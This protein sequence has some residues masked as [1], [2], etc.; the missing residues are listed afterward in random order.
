L[1][2][3]GNLLARINGMRKCFKGQ[4]TMYLLLVSVFIVSHYGDILPE[5]EIARYD[6]PSADID[7][8]TSME[9]LF[10]SIVD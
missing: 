10:G 3:N 5:A 9:R 7:G 8:L 4:L 2:G 1:D 6:Q